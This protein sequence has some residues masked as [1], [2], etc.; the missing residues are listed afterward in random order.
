MIDV[1]LQRTCFNALPIPLSGLAFKHSTPEKSTAP[2]RSV[3]DDTCDEN[4][5][6]IKAIYESIQALRS[7]VLYHPAARC[8]CETS[9]G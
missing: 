8:R 1:P 3:I 4:K 6:K 9:E 7:N 2:R 5:Y